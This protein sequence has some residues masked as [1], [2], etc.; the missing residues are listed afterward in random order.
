[1]AHRAEPR[2][3]PTREGMAAAANDR[4]VTACRYELARFSSKQLEEAGT[5]LHVIGHLIG[6]DRVQGNSPF[7]HGND[8]TVAVSMLLR[9]AGQLTS[10]IT[11]LFADGR[12][13]AAAALLRQMVEIEYLAWAFET[14]NGDAERWLRSD[15][16]ERQN[17]FT[18]AKLRDAAQGTFRSKDYGYH[19]ELGGHPVPLAG[20]LLGE[21]SAIGQLLLSDLLGHV[22]R[23]WNHL[24]G[25]ARQNDNGGPILQRSR[26]M[27]VRFREWTSKDALVD[28]P[29][30]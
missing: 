1:M 3:E 25:W 16:K 8:E 5:E 30:P 21:D 23:I 19:C 11:D 20:I 7:G 22:G 13:Y 9:V 6:T 28:L 26:E 14:R 10:A 12:Q 17:F 4:E 15:K 27:S 18:P 24:A 29:P 2:I